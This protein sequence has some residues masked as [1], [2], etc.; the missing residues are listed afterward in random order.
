LLVD[1]RLTW[2]L[3]LI[4]VSCLI[5][6]LFNH[7]HFTILGMKD[8]RIIENIQA[9]LLLLFAFVSYFYIKPLQLHEDKKAFW[10]WAI[11]WWILLFGR[12]TS[13]GRD[14]FPEVP[15]M[16]FRGISIVLIGAV[17]FPLLSKVLRRE[18][19]N[20]FKTAVL[21]VWALVLAVVGLIISDAIEHQRFI[22][23]LLLTENG[24]RD[25][26]E[27]LYEF[28]LILSLFAISFSLMKADKSETIS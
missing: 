11:C 6:P 4:A 23:M 17:V 7:V 25:L 5:F 14:Y 10:L 18:I 21:P 12:S 13:W 1:T 2:P 8:V 9:L 22:G 3:F 15:K 27:E 16:Y 26:M 28:P 20:K 24:N 19:M